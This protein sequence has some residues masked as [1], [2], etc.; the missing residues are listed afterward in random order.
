MKSYYFKS[1]LVRESAEPFHFLFLL[2]ATGA[3]ST[4]KGPHRDEPCQQRGSR[5]AS[6]GAWP[7]EGPASPFP[8][9]RPRSV[10]G[11]AFPCIAG[12]S[13]LGNLASAKR[14]KH[15][16][17]LQP[18]EIPLQKC[19]KEALFSWRIWGLYYLSKGW[20]RIQGRLGFTSHPLTWRQHILLLVLL[21][22]LVLNA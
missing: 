14:F 19:V 2:W 17:I 3:A 13:L 21:F 18:Y 7:G 22:C 8:L 5:A 10:S 1:S 6:G 9:Q 12:K 11:F 20:L 4:Q 16:N 15:G